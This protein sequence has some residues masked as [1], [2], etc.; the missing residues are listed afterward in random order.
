MCYG[1]GIDLPMGALDTRE[2]A[3]EGGELKWFRPPPKG[4]I[5][6]AR[7]QVNQIA[8]AKTRAKLGTR[9]DATAAIVWVTTATR[10][11]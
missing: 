3:H 4:S 2:L 9:G 6:R 1:S 11:A 10:A 5:P 8:I 7:N